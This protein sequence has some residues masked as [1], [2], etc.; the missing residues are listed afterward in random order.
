MNCQIVEEFSRRS[1][2]PIFSSWAQAWITFPRLLCTWHDHVTEFRSMKYKWSNGI[3]F[4]SSVSTT[5][6]KCHSNTEN[7]EGL[8]RGSYETYKWAHEWHLLYRKT[9]GSL[10]KTDTDI[11]IMLNC[12]DSGVREHLP[13][14]ILTSVDIICLW[15]CFFVL[16]LHFWDACFFLTFLHHLYMC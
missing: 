2:N 5:P 13:L 4:P 14:P 10:H 7:S 12:G 15:I 3:L 1:L 6:P 8:E 16:F 9:Y 11:H